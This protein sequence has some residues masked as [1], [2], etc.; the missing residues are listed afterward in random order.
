[1]SSSKFSDSSLSQF[2]IAVLTVSLQLLQCLQNIFFKKYKKILGKTYGQPPG[3]LSNSP[4]TAA[5][6]TR[7]DKSM[8]LFLFASPLNDIIFHSGV[9][10]Q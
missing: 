10:T 4:P 9:T 5:N 3:I 8:D 2:L 6:N 1:M 7:I